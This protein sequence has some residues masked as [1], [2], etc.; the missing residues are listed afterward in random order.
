MNGSKGLEQAEAS[1]AHL[2]AQYAK[3]A[4][5]PDDTERRLAALVRVEPMGELKT[6]NQR[7]FFVG[8]SISDDKIT[9]R[10][11]QTELSAIVSEN[12]IGFCEIGKAANGIYVI[13]NA[14]VVRSHQRRGIATAVYDLIA[15]DMSKIGGILWPVS[16]KKMTEAEFKVWWRRSPALVFY[17]PHRYRLGLDPRPEFEQ[18]FDE[19]MS[20]S[21]R[22]GFL[23]RISTM[24]SRALRSA[25]AVFAKADKS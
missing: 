8:R 2:I 20:V 19:A 7:P 5:V 24:L 12:A 23:A 13:D 14:E 21:F 4:Q 6:K 17:Y 1:Y 10:V 9:Y 25:G 15:S 18:L 16:P 3:K 11:F 22:Q